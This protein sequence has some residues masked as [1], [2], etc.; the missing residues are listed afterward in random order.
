MLVGHSYGG[1]VNTEA[2][3]SARNVT[4]LVLPETAEPSATLSGKFPGSTLS[5]AL[6][7]GRLPGGH[8]DLYIPPATFPAQFAADLPPTEAALMSTALIHDRA[9]SGPATCGGR[10][11]P[12]ARLKGLGP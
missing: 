8:H 4:A 12:G 5:S 11:G 7:P 3:S 2:A 6:A 9:G 1:P 10:I